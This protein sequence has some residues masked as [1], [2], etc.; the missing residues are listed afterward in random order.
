[1]NTF[2]FT[3]DPGF[4]CFAVGVAMCDPGKVVT[5]GGIF[6]DILSADI[7]MLLSAANAT[8]TAW[9]GGILNETAQTVTWHIQAICVDA[10]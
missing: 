7:K 6:T 10:G 2:D 4:A 1:M 3:C 8:S 5:G 9:N